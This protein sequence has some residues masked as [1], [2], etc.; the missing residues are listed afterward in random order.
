MENR[1]SGDEGGVEVRSVDVD[2]AKPVKNKMDVEKWLEH[3]RKNR[4]NRV[5]PDWEAPI[6]ISGQQRSDL[7]RSL[8]QFQLGDGGGPASLIAW[9]RENFLGG[10]DVM[11]LLVGMWFKEEEEHSRLLG[12]ALKRFGVTPI[13]N[14]WSFS[15]FCKVR[16][17]GGVKFELYALLLTE[18]TSHV[19]H[20]MLRRHCPDAAVKGVCQMIIRDEAGHIAFHRARL[21]WV[22]GRRY[23]FCWEAYFIARGLAAGTVLWVNHG[24]ALRNFGATSFEFYRGIWRGM[25][26][27]T[28]GLRSD[29]ARGRVVPADFFRRER[30]LRE[31]VAS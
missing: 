12:G 17:L 7:E 16:V 24:K 26:T 30:G 8:Q 14:H 20:K 22:K 2:S 29:L 13:S 31:K 27:F 9:N 28:R 11:R 21:G 3:F 1:D 15:L 23:G 4:L 10:D 19:Y 25:R 5:E 6:E 18:I